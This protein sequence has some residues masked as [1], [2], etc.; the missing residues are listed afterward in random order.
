[1]VTEKK[2]SAER[3]SAIKQWCQNP[4]IDDD[5]TPTAASGVQLRC[6]IDWLRTRLCHGHACDLHVICFDYAS[7]T[8]LCDCSSHY[9]CCSGYVMHHDW[10]VLCAAKHVCCTT[11]S[12]HDEVI[13]DIYM[14]SLKYYLVGTLMSYQPCACVF[15]LHVS[16]S[17][18]LWLC[19]FGSCIIRIVIARR[20]WR[21]HGG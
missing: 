12:D 4:N 19:M 9:E 20:A 6:K 11:G 1:M 3:V 18:G 10:V 21:V 16:C 17:G 7:G 15:P 5:A 2:F 14:D 8:V 13:S